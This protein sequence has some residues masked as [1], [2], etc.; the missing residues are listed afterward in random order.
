MQNK[1]RPNIVSNGFPYA[2]LI[3]VFKFDMH[4]ICK[5]MITFLC[6]YLYLSF[7]VHNQYI[8]E[9]QFP[10]E[11]EMIVNIIL[12]K[13]IITAIEIEAQNIKIP[14][15]FSKTYFGTC[16]EFLPGCFTYSLIKK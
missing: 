4:F 14:K 15:D 7:P 5:Y 12:E 6:M 9:E 11:P 10:P 2:F 13:H 8:A 16:F 3:R 1:R